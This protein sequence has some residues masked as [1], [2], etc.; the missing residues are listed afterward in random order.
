MNS[1]DKQ[2]KLLQKNQVLKIETRYKKLSG[3]Q[4]RRY[5]AM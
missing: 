4:Y 1:S 3:T 2:H 5:Q